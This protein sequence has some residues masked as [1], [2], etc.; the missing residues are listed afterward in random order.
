MRRSTAVF[1]TVLAAVLCLAAPAAR[2]AV[3]VSIYDPRQ[4][5][6]PPLGRVAEVRPERLQLPNGITVYL[7]EDHTLPVVRGTAWF[8][9][10]PTWVADDKVGLAAL[11][12]EVMR[13]GGSKAHSGDFLDD[14]LAAIGAELSASVG[15]DLASSSFRCLADN[16]AEVLGLWASMLRAPAFPDDKIEQSKVGLR[17][18]IASRNDEMLTILL[19]VANQAIYGKG[20]PWARQ[21]EYATVEAISAEDCR[22]LHGR[23]FVPERM[24]VALYGDFKSA[25]MRKLLLARFG[26]WRKSG[27][28][29]PVLPPTPTAVAPKVVYAPKDDVTQ[30]G[31]VVA[32]MGLRADDPDYAAMQ[33]LEQG[34]GGG[35]A[36]RMFSRIRTQRGLAY[37]TGAQ[38]GVDWQRPGLFVAFSLTKS[39]STMVA[40]GLVREEVRKVTEAPF[41]AA[42]LDVAKGA[43]SN[44]FVFNFEDASQTLFRAAQYE[45]FGYPQDFLARYQKALE[46]VSAQGVL[47]AAKRRIQPAEQIVILVGREKDFDRPLESLGLPVERVDVTIPPPPSRTGKVAATPEAK[48]K[49]RAWLDAAAKAVGGREAWAKVKGYDITSELTVS[50]QGQQIALTAQERKLFPDKQLSIQKLPFGEVTQGFDGTA[51]WVSAMGQLQDNPR[52]AEEFAKNKERSLWRLLSDP[53]VE[54]VAL[55]AKETVDGVAYDAALVAG[56]KSQD[57]TLFFD[58][59]GRL[60]GLSMMEDNPQLGPGRMVQLYSDWKPV[61]ALQYPRGLTITREGKPFASGKVTAVVLDPALAPEIFAKPAK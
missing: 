6:T 14:R 9:A 38:A 20:S 31:I 46:G 41:S 42:E 26:D 37:S 27:T 22:T 39:E 8:R 30:T 47:E 55:E 59:Q 36:S 18:G 23:V 56:A 32:Q 53:T 48:A 34:L 43:V 29:A 16:T 4:L 25:E 24:V 19:R 1:R 13:T 61:G 49:G 54:L 52:A 40:L 33:V 50:V 2:A 12:G 7:L 57:L 21:P 5:P 15:S 60:A 11:V 28:P 44:A 51:G 17:R 45:V 58:A 3:D 10:T 35:F